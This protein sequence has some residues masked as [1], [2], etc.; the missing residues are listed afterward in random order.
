MN[1]VTDL[2]LVMLLAVFPQSEARDVV[3][4]GVAA[5]R[6]ADYNSAVEYFKQALELDP[7][8]TT[9]ELYLATAYAQQYTPGSTSPENLAAAEK[10]IQSF[11]RVLR[12]EPDN[13]Q[14]VLGLASIYQNTGDLLSARENYTRATTLDP[15]NPIPFYSVGAVDWL[16]VYKNSRTLPIPE[17]LHLIDEGLENLDRAIA[18]NPQFDDA[19][20]YKNLLIRQQ[21]R[22]AA[23]PAERDRLIALADDWFNKALEVRK[24]NADMRRFGAPPNGTAVIG[25]TPPPPPAPSRQ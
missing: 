6:K 17:Q 12:R 7:N 23:S 3:N 21:A 14:T 24:R 8:S 22:L 18:L 9:T 1:G 10:A 11:K 20:T 19:M 2:I 5:F 16:V 13:A 15:Q 25:V 4:K